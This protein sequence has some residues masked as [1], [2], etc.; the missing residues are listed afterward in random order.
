MGF[1]ATIRELIVRKGRRIHY[2]DF[3]KNRDDEPKLRYTRY[4][5]LGK[6]CHGNSF[7]LCEKD[8]TK[9]IHYVPEYADYEE[10]IDTINIIDSD[11][12]LLREYAF[13]DGHSKI[14]TKKLLL[15]LSDGNLIIEKYAFKKLTI[16]ESLEVRRGRVQLNDHIFQELDF[17]KS[18]KLRV[19][20]KFVKLN[21]ALKDVPNLES[22]EILDNG[23]IGICDSFNDEL[24]LSQLQYTGGK[25][26]RIS[27]NSFK[28]LTQL[29]TL[30]I[31]ETYLSVIEADAFNNLNKL[32]MLSITRNQYLSCIPPHNNDIRMN[33]ITLDLSNNSIKAIDKNSFI[34]M[35]GTDCLLLNLS[36]N[37][38][39]VLKNKSFEYCQTID[40]SANQ[41]IFIDDDVFENAVAEKILM[42]ENSIIDFEDYVRWGVRKINIIHFDI[43][44][45]EIADNHNSTLECI[46][47]KC[48]SSENNI[49]E[50]CKKCKT[51]LSVT[52][53]SMPTRL[54]PKVL[55]ISDNKLSYI[56]KQAFSNLFIE[57]LI[58][59]STSQ[60]LT[61]NSETFEGLST[62]KN[63]IFKTYP[64][65]IKEFNMNTLKNLEHLVISLTLLTQIELCIYVEFLTSLKSIIVIEH[66][67]AYFCN[68]LCKYKNTKLQYLQYQKG[69]FE[70]I[71]S[72][73]FKCLNGLNTLII[74]DSNLKTFDTGAFD[75]LEN[76]DTLIL[77]NNKIP[78]INKNTFSGLLKLKKLSLAHNLISFID[79]D[80]F[81]LQKSNYL[82]T[83][84]TFHEKNKDFCKP[85][86]LS[87]LDLS[88]N[89]LKHLRNNMLNDIR[90][91]FNI[92]G[93]KNPREFVSNLVLELY[94]N[95]DFLSIQPFA[96]M[97]MTDKNQVKT[98]TIDKHSR[99]KFIF[100]R[101]I[102]AGLIA[103]ENL[104]LN[105]GPVKVRDRYFENLHN[106]KSL[107]IE[108]I[109][110]EFYLIETLQYLFLLESLEI[111]GNASVGICSNPFAD[112]IPPITTLSYT[113]G[114]ITI[115]R[116]KSLT[117]LT[118]LENFKISD[119]LLRTL[120]Q[121]AFYGLSHLKT[122]NLAHNELK[123]IPIN[124]FNHIHTLNVLELNYNH[125]AKIDVDPLTLEKI[126]PNDRLLLLDLS[127]NKL[128]NLNQELEGLKCKV[129]DLSGNYIQSSYILIPNSCIRKIIMSKNNIISAYDHCQS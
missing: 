7:P 28:C 100:E 56:E 77:E 101:E 91:K 24:I 68:D 92:F 88:F 55:E 129:L 4:T 18:L 85:E 87:V 113:S 104:E 44:H 12:R 31:T 119:T 89:K 35:V 65:L 79:D 73:S 98:L 61:L 22:L 3:L 5:D 93:P 74:N 8:S 21:Q 63:L 23:T 48:Y 96:F 26:D 99:G 102:F 47:Q 121:D 43:I 115:L 60:N 51:L 124:V 58:I 110:D 103:L 90:R 30:K 40:L 57:T 11:I 108:A 17:L 49:F 52:L 54:S 20:E 62:L 72:K 84:C 105:V 59:A 33:L 97:N 116:K 14:K 19:N 15:S 127:N 46:N 76:L 70:K 82:P 39:D 27:D 83:D 94:I 2:G 37:A 118:Y 78:L 71:P 95:D 81:R 126:F 50:I 41:M 53:K 117:C 34:K 38:L 125:I 6:D 67:S 45:H 66:T 29:K 42:N 36:Y 9:L 109:D 122:I 32:E 106:L 107:K 10:D 75:G 111:V 16:L 128:K 1:P 80:A 69:S 13:D 25:I 112:S 114:S 86:T 64:I 123:Y 120:E